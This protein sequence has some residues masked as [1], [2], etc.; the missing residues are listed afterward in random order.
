[1]VELTMTGNEGRSAVQAAHRPSIARAI[2]EWRQSGI[3]AALLITVAIFT[4]LDR[5]FFTSYN[6]FNILLQSS[7]TAILAMAETFIIVTAGIDLSIGAAVALTATAS[8][9]MMASVP[10]PVVIAGSLLTGAL[11]GL[12]NGLVITLSRITPF[13][14]TLGTMSIFA[15]LALIISGG[16]T[17]YG[18]PPEFIRMLSGSIGP[19]PM[20]V[21]V[22]LAVMAVSIIIMR[23]TK[24]GEYLIAIGGAHEVARLAGIKVS[25]YTATAYAIAGVLA[26]IAGMLTVARLGAADPTLGQDLLLPAIAATVMGGANLQGGEGSMVGAAI[27]ALLIATL[28]AG[29]TFLNVQSFYQQ[30]AIGV[31]IILS[32]LFNRLQATRR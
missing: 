14:V 9:L 12:A 4:I 25:F 2:I 19:V 29:L 24:L 5:E 23:S 8:G 18:V 10:L 3:V 6:F 28:Q 7:I 30:V 15:G 16:Q 1:M 32:L 21:I 20:P 13:V 22:A 26:A 11:S 31:V 27:G 17:I